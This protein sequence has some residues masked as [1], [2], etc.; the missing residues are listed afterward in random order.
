MGVTLYQNNFSSDGLSTAFLGVSNSGSLLPPTGSEAVD[1][2]VTASSDLI[3][4]DDVNKETYKRIFH[5]LPFL[6]KTKGT[7]T[8]LRTL[9]NTYGIPDTI[10]RISEFGGKD[11]DNTNDWDYYQ[12]KFNYAAY[13]SGSSTTSF[14]SSSF[15]LNSKWDE[16]GHSISPTSV[17]LRFKPSNI[18]PSSDEYAI[19]FKLDGSTD[20]HLTLTYTGSAYS[21]A[22]YSGS[23][24]SSSNE[25]ATLTYWLGS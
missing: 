18:L 15:T 23:I 8:G 22:S 1:D 19:V 16:N 10:L 14:I 11:I 25:Y 4:F 20:G 17:L 7:V 24:P 21:S 5:N 2:Y 12:S 6:L 9:I 3:K 13:N